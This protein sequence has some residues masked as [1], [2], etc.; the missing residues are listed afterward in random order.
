MRMNE[1]E[2]DLVEVTSHF[3]A[4]PSHVE[5]QGQVYSGALS[6]VSIEYV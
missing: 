2:C 5:W 4:R 1:M 6:I 3:G